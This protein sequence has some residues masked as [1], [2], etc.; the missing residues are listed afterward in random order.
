MK[1]AD[2]RV[3]AAPETEIDSFRSCLQDALDSSEWDDTFAIERQSI[4]SRS[5]ARSGTF[6]LSGLGCGSRTVGGYFPRH[7]VIPAVA[8]I[9]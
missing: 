2:R 5:G 8:T 7:H 4:Q 1:V 6:S 3:H 9:L